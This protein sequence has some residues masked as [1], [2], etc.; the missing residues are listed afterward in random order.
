[1]AKGYS[2]EIRMKIKNL[3][4]Q[5]FILPSH[6][7]DDSENDASGIGEGVPDGGLAAGDEALA[8]F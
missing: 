5:P 6:I 7:N 1:M 4:H 2:V 8:K 3:F